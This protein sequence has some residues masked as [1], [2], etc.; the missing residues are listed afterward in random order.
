MSGEVLEVCMYNTTDSSTNIIFGAYTSE[1][2]KM[3][4]LTSPYLF[5]HL[6]VTAWGTLKRFA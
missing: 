4:M 3:H 2:L 6:H 1:I 5:I